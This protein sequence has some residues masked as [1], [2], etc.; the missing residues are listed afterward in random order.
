MFTVRELIDSLEELA[1]D[2][3]D[4]MPVIIIRQDVPVPIS[5]LSVE[6]TNPFLARTD[7]PEEAEKHRKAM[8]LPTPPYLVL[9]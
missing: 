2:N 1:Q 8:G 6:D 4:T 9:E 7:N 5:A 3:G